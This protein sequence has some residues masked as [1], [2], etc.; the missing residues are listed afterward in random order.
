MALPISEQIAV[1]VKTRLQELTVANGYETEASGVVRP[2]RL[3][4]FVPRDYLI[5][6]TQLDAKHNLPLSCP[7]N[8][9]AKAWDVQFVVAGLLKTSETITTAI[10]TLKNTFSADVQKALCDPAASW[11]N[12]D[13]LAL[14][15]NVGEVIETAAEDGSL[16]GFHTILTITY[17]TDEADPYTL[18]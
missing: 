18:R 8:P 16:V 11:H 4:G 14:N 5:V 1:K 17:R 3:G 6:I 13:G 12:W 10:A 15:S 2:T 7:G 9:P